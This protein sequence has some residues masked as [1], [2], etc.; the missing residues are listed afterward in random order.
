MNEKMKT[1]FEIVPMGGQ[2]AMS[3]QLNMLTRLLL[4]AF[5]ATLLGSALATA[6]CAL[7]CQPATPCPCAADGTCR[8]Q[9][10]WGHSQT[11]W[12]PWP[13]DVIDKKPTT[14]EEEQKQEQLR[15]EPYETPV[16]EKE[17]L[18]GSETPESRKKK[19]RTDDEAPAGDP[20]G[21]LEQDLGGAFP[22]AEPAVEPQQPIE[23]PQ[24]FGQPAEID[25]FEL[26]G[27]AELEQPL[28]D[29]PLPEG[30]PL[31]DFDPFSDLNYKREVP[32][33][34]HQPATTSPQ[35]PASGPPTLPASLQKLSRTMGPMPPS[36]TNLRE[37]RYRSTSAV[38]LAN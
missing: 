22:G 2:Q 8:P 20:L 7:D 31:D 32:R 30:K 9:G 16:P 33:T 17:S 10:P 15:L 13:G 11:R 4:F 29:A 1:H 12:R 24:P 28:E 23:Q 19:S 35:L 3:R 21:G 18:R 34:A 37:P 5:A 38:A 36:R 14:V 6:A 26:P 27:G 25:G